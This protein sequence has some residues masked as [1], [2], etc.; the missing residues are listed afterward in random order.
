MHELSYHDWRKRATQHDKSVGG[1][2]RTPRARAYKEA[3]VESNGNWPT[4]NVRLFED[5][6][7]IVALLVFDTWTELSGTWIEAQ[8][9]LIELMSKHVLSWEAKAWDGYLVLLTLA[10]VAPNETLEPTQIRYDTH[11]V[12]KILATGDELKRLPD[13]ERRTFA[14]AASRPWVKYRRDGVVTRPASRP[15]V[16]IWHLRAGCQSTC[17]FLSA[18]TLLKSRET[19]R[20]L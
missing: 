2:V 18:G 6:Y 1:G 10:L 4:K 14:V 9:A 16:G 13:V 7:S 5:A 3:E 17:G 12:R 20:W 11:R 8:T 15:L 19:G